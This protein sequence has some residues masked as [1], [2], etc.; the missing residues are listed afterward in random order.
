M[1][2]P[3]FSEIL[4]DVIK[5]ADLQMTFEKSTTSDSINISIWTR[6]HRPRSPDSPCY[7]ERTFSEPVYNLCC[8]KS[9][10][11]TKTRHTL[12]EILSE[13]QQASRI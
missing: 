7:F 6:L 11:T 10:E 13:I 4:L 8:V 9:L 2:P 5:D 3:I 1:R 12:V